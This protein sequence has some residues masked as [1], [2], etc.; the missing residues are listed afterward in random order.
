MQ[1]SAFYFIIYKSKQHNLLATIYISE[2]G[3]RMLIKTAD[4]RGFHPQ[5]W[6]KAGIL[7]ERWKEIILSS[8][9]FSN[10]SIEGIE[11]CD[12]VLTLCSCWPKNLIRI[13]K[14][15]PGKEGSLKK[16]LKSKQQCKT[17]TESVISETVKT[18]VPKVN[19]NCA[20]L[21]L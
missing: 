10:N 18:K 3:V 1:I 14:V 5:G 20:F 4:N 2:K 12:I 6:M 13:C 7:R 16:I 19:D 9:Y 8:F 15:N 21:N 17:L 11:K